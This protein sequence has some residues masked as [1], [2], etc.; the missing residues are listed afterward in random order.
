[1]KIQDDK[2]IKQAIGLEPQNKIDKK[3]DGFNKALSEARS[4]VEGSPK[5]NKLSPDEIQKLNFRLQSA[6]SIPKLETSGFSEC[7]GKVQKAEI[8]KVEQF[9]EILESYMQ[10]LSDPKKNLREVA[11][12]VKSLEIEKEKLAELGEDLPDGGV[13]KHIVNQTVILSTMEVLRFNRGDYL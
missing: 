7:F 1:M 5:K 6:S 12:L 13:L 4:K 8:K 3:S 10:A 11:S 9:L 2:N